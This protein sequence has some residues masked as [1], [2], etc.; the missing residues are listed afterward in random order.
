MKVEK[1]AQKVVHVF[2]GVVRRTL[3][4]GRDVLMA[5]FEYA[6]GSHVP[7]HSH[8]YEQVTTLL[9]GEQKIIIKGSDHN[10]E[11]LVKTGE[12]YIVPPSFKHEQLT[13]KKTVTIDSWSI[14]P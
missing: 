11:F 4:C 1:K 2:E 12:S 7:R 13:L 14:S 10:E 8:T 6:E 9:S 5:R 3:A